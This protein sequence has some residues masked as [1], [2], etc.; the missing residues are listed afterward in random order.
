MTET[1]SLVSECCAAP[2]KQ[3]AKVMLCTGCKGFASEF[4]EGRWGLRIKPESPWEGYLRRR[5]EAKARIEKDRRRANLVSRPDGWWEHG[6]T[7]R[8]VIQAILGYLPGT[9]EGL[10]QALLNEDK[11]L[12]VVDYMLECMTSVEDGEVDPSWK[13]LPNLI[14]QNY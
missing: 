5:E 7:H 6:A 4:E 8:S 1:I 10:K 12:K 3:V 2:V 14:K 9:W 11:E 13:T